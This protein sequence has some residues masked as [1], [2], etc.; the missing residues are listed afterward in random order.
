MFFSKNLV[1]IF[2]KFQI[3]FITTFFLFYFIR[4]GFQ[5]LSF[6]LDNLLPLLIC[7]L[8]F[9]GI[10]LFVAFFTLHERKLM[11]FMQRRLGPNKLGF[12]FGQPFADALKLLT[13][14]FVFP[15]DAH[16]GFFL[17]SAILSFFL[18]LF[19]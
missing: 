11:G 3:F 16:L 12:G 5:Q 8:V 18:S 4:L 9:I 1:N 15:K 14:E 17:F 10:L 13:K 6:I 7:L 2:L 19:I